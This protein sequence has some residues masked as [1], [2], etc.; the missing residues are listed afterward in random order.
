[1]WEMSSPLSVHVCVS[2]W[3]VKSHEGS[4]HPLHAVGGSDRMIRQL[5]EGDLWGGGGVM[6]H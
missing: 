3:E 2:I 1:M 6:A 4:P 5:T